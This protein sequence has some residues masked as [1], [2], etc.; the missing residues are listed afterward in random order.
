MDYRRFFASLISH[1]TVLLEGE[2]LR[3][4]VQVTRHKVGYD[5]IA[6]T[7]DGYDYLCRITE[8][9]KQELTAKILC[10]TANISEPKQQVVLYQA[11]CKELDFIVQKAVE[12]GATKIVPFYSNN[13]N[14][15]NFKLERFKKIVVDASKQ[16]GRGVLPTI[17]EPVQFAE[18]IDMSKDSKNRVIC[19]EKCKE[20]RFCN[21]DDSG[22][23]A[24]YIGSEGGFTQEEIAYAEQS[25]VVVTTLGK[26]ILRAETASIVALTKCMSALGEM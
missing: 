5:F 19:Y 14:V 11:V 26:R 13:T 10:K 6:T 16:C 8:I 20:D 18:A 7:G 23:I 15:S 2:E 24:L 12:L 1:D 22:D 25:G 21:I 9:N 4:C 3:H 17:Q